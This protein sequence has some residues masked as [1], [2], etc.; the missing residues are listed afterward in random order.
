MCATERVEL[1]AE[2]TC[3]THIHGQPGLMCLRTNHLFRC[4]LGHVRLMTRLPLSL[5][6]TGEGGTQT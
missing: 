2:A 5:K 1:G 4:C 6:Y 3:A